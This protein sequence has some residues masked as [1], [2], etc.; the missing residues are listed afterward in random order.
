MIYMNMSLVSWYSEKQSTIETSVYG[1]GFVAMKV[2]AETLCVIQY[3]FRMMCILISE[4][5]IFMK[6]TCQLSIIT[7]SH[8]LNLWEVSTN[9]LS[10]SWQ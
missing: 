8:H 4:P 6:I 10:D 3:K 7:Q 2:G 9:F 5:H 1:A